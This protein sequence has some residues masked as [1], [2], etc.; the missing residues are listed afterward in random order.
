MG[1]YI[2]YVSFHHNSTSLSTFIHTTKATKAP[3]D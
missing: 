1:L 3:V 2:N